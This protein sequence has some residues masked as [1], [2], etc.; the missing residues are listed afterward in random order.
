MNVHPADLNSLITKF[1]VRSSMRPTRMV[2]NAY[3]KDT[4]LSIVRPLPTSRCKALSARSIPRGQTKVRSRT[5]SMHRSVGFS[6]LCTCF[7]I[8]FATP[9]LSKC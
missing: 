4:N 1:N 3:I 5:I 2:W 8:S 6:V 9:N 7:D